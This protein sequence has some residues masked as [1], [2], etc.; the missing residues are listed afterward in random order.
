MVIFIY[1]YVLYSMQKK[2]LLFGFHFLGDQVYDIIFG[3]NKLK[4]KSSF[5]FLVEFS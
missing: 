2:L 4:H 5:E 3:V 1:F